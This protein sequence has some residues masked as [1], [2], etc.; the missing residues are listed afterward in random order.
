MRKKMRFRKRRKNQS[1]VMFGL[2]T[3][4]TRLCKRWNISE[5]GMKLNSVLFMI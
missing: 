2:C 1:S 5:V 3:N 4:I